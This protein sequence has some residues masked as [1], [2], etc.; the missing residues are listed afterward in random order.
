MYGVVHTFAK[1]TKSGII[2][3]IGDKVWYHPDYM[4]FGCDTCADLG[5]CRSGHHDKS[6]CAFAAKCGIGHG[7][8]WQEVI[9]NND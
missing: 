2:R 3:E 8:T 6:F 5:T 7:N 1:I 4:D 9:E